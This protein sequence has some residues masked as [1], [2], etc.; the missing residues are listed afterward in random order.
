MEYLISGE[1]NSQ[2]HQYKGPNQR[3]L[4]KFLS[5]L[6]SETSETISKSF[7]EVLTIMDTKKEN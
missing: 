5:K 6:N 7:L 4:D 1:T 2:I 3:R